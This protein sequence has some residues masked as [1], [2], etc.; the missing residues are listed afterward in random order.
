MFRTEMTLEGERVRRYHNLALVRS[1]SPTVHH[2]LDRGPPNHRN[3]ACSSRSDQRVTAGRGRS[4][5]LV[6]FVGVDNTSPRPCTPATA[7][8]SP[9]CAGTSSLK[10]LFQVDEPRSADFADFHKFHETFEVE[11]QRAA[12]QPA[13]RGFRP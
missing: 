3:P 1:Q 9:T 12:P 4:R 11:R 5:I 13:A 7:M 2:D 10:D 6:T 8:P